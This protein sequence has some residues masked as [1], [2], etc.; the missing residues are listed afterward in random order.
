MPARQTTSTQTLVEDTGIAEKRRVRYVWFAGDTIEPQMKYSMPDRAF[1]GLVADSYQTLKH[2]GNPGIVYQCNITA[3]K[4][5]SRAINRSMV[6]HPDQWR[7]GFAIQTRDENGQTKV[8]TVRD[9]RYVYED[10]YPG[11]DVVRLTTERTAPNGEAGV[12]ELTALAGQP[13]SIAARIQFFFFPN[14]NDIQTGMVSLPGTLDE[15]ESHIRARLSASRDADPDIRDI[16]ESCG[17]D[18]LRGCTVYRNWGLGYL[19]AIEND[20]NVA[21]TK[22]VPYTYPAKAVMM[23]KQLKQTRKDDLAQ[24]TASSSNEL[25]AVMAEQNRLRAAELDLERAKV[26]LEMAKA[27]VGMQSTA[28]KAAIPA[29]TV[30]PS[31][32]ASMSNDI[33]PA[34]ESAPHLSV[35]DI[36]AGAVVPT[37]VVPEVEEAAVAET[38]AGFRSDGRR[39]SAMPSH[40][41]NGV[42]Y[43]RHHPK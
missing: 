10:R 2:N 25:I 15:I 27:R 24:N 18:M 37:P 12:I 16:V 43:C 34:L 5:V 38:C 1:G 29:P 22:G 32:E 30:S 36:L 20:F 9:K 40:E 3:L 31:V 42:G 39:C 28:P 23:L 35:A 8:E 41:I 14:W 21:K 13:E 33:D 6:E 17:R 11:N 19:T 26:E 4:P 7:Q